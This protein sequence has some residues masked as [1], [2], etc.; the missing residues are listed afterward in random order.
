MPYVVIKVD[1]F[2]INAISK[3]EFTSLS[4]KVST[5]WRKP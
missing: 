1:F 4:L 3:A 5:F 2:E